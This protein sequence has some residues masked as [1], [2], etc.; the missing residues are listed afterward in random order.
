MIAERKLG[1][2]QLTEDGSVEI[3]G[4]D[5]REKLAADIAGTVVGQGRGAV[6]EQPRVTA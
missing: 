1:G 4:Q 5:L 3:T 6:P 2:G